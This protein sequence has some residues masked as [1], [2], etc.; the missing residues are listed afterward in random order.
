VIGAE[1]LRLAVAC[2]QAPRIAREARS[3]DDAIRIVRESVEANPALKAMGASSLDE[4]EALDLTGQ[5]M[6]SMRPQILRALGRRR[7]AAYVA[8]L[9]KALRENGELP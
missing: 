4:R 8:A 9:V 2:R 5:V 7:D 6:D 1:A 3:D